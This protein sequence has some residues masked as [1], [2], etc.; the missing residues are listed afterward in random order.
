MK[1]VIYTLALILISTQVTLSQT[2]AGRAG[3]SSAAE[4]VA[5]P[6]TETAA[7]SAPPAKAEPASDAAAVLAERQRPVAV[8]RFA[9]P[10]VVD[11][12]LNDEVWKTA[13][14]LKNFF[15]TQPGDNIAPS[16]PTDVLLGR[17]DK[18]LYIA[19][20]ATDEPDKVR[21]TIAKRDAIFDD[22]F[23]GL[24][25]DTYNDKR[26][27]Y[28]LFFNPLGVQADGI[29]T[30]GRGE[31]YTV[32]IVMASKGV[33]GAAGYTVEVAIPFKS[34]RYEAGKGKL[35]GIHFFRRI[36]RFNTE[37]DSWMPLS[38]DTSGTLTQAG[39][40]SG[41]GEV[42]AGRSVEII[43]SLTLSETG[44]RVRTVPRAALLA[45]PGL[46]DPGR[47]L[48]DP[49][50]I[51][52]GLTVKL[53]FASNLTLDL[54]VNPDFAQVEADQTVVTANQR[55]PIFF[56]EKRPFFLEGKEIFETR[57]NVLHT[58]A[59]VDPDL[60]VKLSGKH[61]RNTFGLLLAS[62]N[63]PGNF[64]AEER[65]DPRNLPYLDRNALVGVL[66]LKRDLGGE[67]NVGLIA[68]SY[69]FA[70]LHN[71]VAGADG[72]FRL[73]PQTFVDFQVVGTYSRRATGPAVGGEIP[74][75]AFKGLGYA[76]QYDKTSR[77]FNFNLRGEG[78]SPF[79]RADVGFTQRV[80]TNAER[81]FVRYGSEPNPKA[82]LVSWFVS[83]SVPVSFD[84]QKRI[85]NWNDEFRVGANLRRQTSLSFIFNGGYERVFET[86]FGPG[87]TPTSRG[88]FAGDDNERSTYKKTVGFVFSTKPT[89][90]YSGSFQVIRTTGAFDFD[91]G[92]GVRFPRV[93][94]GALVNPGAQLDP[95][96]GDA[97][98]V[99]GSFVYQ[100]TDKL[101]SSIDYTKSRQTRYD[102]GL[103]AFDVNIYSLRTTYQFTRFLFARGRLD[104]TNAPRNRFRGQYL[105]GWAPNPGTS[106][107]VGYNDDLFHDEVSTFTGQLE[108]GFRRN[109]RTFFVKMS[110]LFGR[111]F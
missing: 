97:L 55:F 20:R 103:T 57:L 66:R 39:H 4:S 28:A 89:K 83:N 95:G 52:P 65:L 76:Y 84:W 18:N 51:D 32:D 87:R 23:V 29:L 67:S 8:P 53:G 16:R 100:P 2:A 50:K 31:D 13:T 15:Q 79:Y 104:V 56:D 77:H 109:G 71:E 69:R 12:Q 10:V 101:R 11:G 34:L 44:R 58:R 102:T 82:K 105:L 9:Q 19:F 81:F 98:V 68:T 85:Q 22:D 107:Y 94:P 36:Q 62:D 45:Q 21:A 110:Y 78:R 49:M 59:I 27:A 91:F 54:A 5:A 47:L 26:R 6:M 14:V 72:R 3:E 106:L 48:N 90:T 74:T 80:N 7:A 93:S 92:T 99:Q 70:G 40:L 111:N 86:E 108:P 1:T 17:D 30:E 35:W 96:P 61:G 60:A 37:L 42:S 33:V 41:L 25:L 75:D 64:N 88:A 73:D 63:A 43:P 46:Q 24:Y 38:R